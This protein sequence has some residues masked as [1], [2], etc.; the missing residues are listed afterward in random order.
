MHDEYDGREPADAK[1]RSSLRIATGRILGGAIGIVAALGVVT[2]VAPQTTGTLALAQIFLPHIVIVTVVLGGMCALA[3]RTRAMSVAL[4]AVILVAAFRF[5]SD[6]VS[7]PAPVA[8]GMPVKLLTWNLEVGARPPSA[9]AGPI[10]GHD[11]DVVALQELTPG[12]S[13]AL[14]TDPAIA[15]RYPYRYLAPDRGVFGIGILSAYPILTRTAF[16]G[17]AGVIVTL[18]LGGGRH[19]AILNAHPLPGEIST[20]GRTAIPIAF[21]ATERDADTATIRSRIDALLARPDPVIA[22]GDYNTTPTEPGYA[23]LAA[24]LR[25]VQTEVGEGP[26]WTWRPS[27]TEW[28]G[29]AVLRIDLVLAGPGVQPLAIAEDCTHVGDHCLVAATVSIR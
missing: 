10:L 17:P 9:V 5:G 11:A 29:I 16:F 27:G 23:R 6:W 2:A 1:D 22:V 13:N 21:D 28:L 24:G 12:A 18:D 25:D 7:F 4:V 14:D 20:F 15:Q 19:V 3:V 8:T 26:G